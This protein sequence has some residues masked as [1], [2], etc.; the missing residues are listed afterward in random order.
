MSIFLSIVG[1]EVNAPSCFYIL[2][3]C[4]GTVVQMMDRTGASDDEEDMG[5]GDLVDLHFGAI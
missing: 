1:V 4:I 2:L 5:E 3:L